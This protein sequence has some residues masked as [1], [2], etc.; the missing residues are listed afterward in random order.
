[1]SSKVSSALAAATV[2]PQGGVIEGVNPTVF[3]PK[4]PIVLFIIQV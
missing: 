1:M 4:Q 2:V 3:D